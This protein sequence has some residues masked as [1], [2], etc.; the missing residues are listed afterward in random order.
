MRT[1]DCEQ[2][3]V[4]DLPTR[5]FHWALVGSVA[6]G[7]LLGE[8]RTF[9]TMNWH[10]YMGYTTAG[11][12][13]LRIVW[14]MIGAQPSR[15]SA[16]FPA[17][18]QLIV[19]IRA[20]GQREPGGAPGHSP[21]GALSVLAMLAA[22][23][24]Q[25]ISGQFAEDDGLFSAGPLASYVEPAMVL[26]MTAIHSMSSWV[27]LGLIVLHV[28]AIIFYKVWKRENLTRAMITGWKTVRVRSG[29]VDDSD[30]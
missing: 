13:V 14:G 7:W 3:K 27:V 29:D 8:F 4:W 18:R 16:L 21:L 1:E 28:A 12:I 10:F 24:V 11:L 5:L 9:S 19:Y 23:V 20:L 22:L 30:Q 2:Q 17:P 15:L 26:K 6:T 25:I